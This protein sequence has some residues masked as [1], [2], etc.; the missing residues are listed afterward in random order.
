MGKF[1]D[2]DVGLTFIEVVIIHRVFK[3]KEFWFKDRAYFFNFT[4]DFTF[5]P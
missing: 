2:C 3:L 5:K 1:I 4:Q